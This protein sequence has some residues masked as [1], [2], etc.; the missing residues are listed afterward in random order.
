MLD[1]KLDELNQLNHVSRLQI[2]EKEQELARLSDTYNDLNERL[3]NTK[4]EGEYLYARLAKLRH[5]S[6]VD[7]A[8]RDVRARGVVG[9]TSLT[10]A[11]A[12]GSL[13]STLAGGR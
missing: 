8:R 11:L 9:G 5:D 3:R 12:A 2:H 10:G 4:N 6:A 1:T 7:E 13:F